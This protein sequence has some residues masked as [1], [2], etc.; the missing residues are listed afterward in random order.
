[1]ISPFKIESESEADA[2]L[3]DLLSKHENRSMR[4]V[5]ERAT[6]LISDAVLRVYFINK[7]RELLD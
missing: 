3:K 4:E 1:M 6:Q 5:E 7:A 2:Y